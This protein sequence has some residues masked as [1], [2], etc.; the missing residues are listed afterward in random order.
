MLNRIPASSL[1]GKYFK[2]E[3]SIDILTSLTCG[4]K[5]L[6]TIEEIISWFTILRTTIE[7]NVER[8]QLNELE[9]WKVT[10]D[11]IYHKDNKYFEIII[12]L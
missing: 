8:C 2:N 1:I 11:I 9:E 7:L 12:C 3:F 10:E 5:S 4:D 6:H